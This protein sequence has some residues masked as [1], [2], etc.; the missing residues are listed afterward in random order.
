[1]GQVIKNS[2]VTVFLNRMCL[3]SCV[4]CNVVD[5]NLDKRRMYTNLWKDAFSILEKEG[6][7]F[8]L[9]IGTEPL[10]MRSGL[11]DLVKFWKERDYEYGL[12]TTA[13][14]GL[15]EELSPK[16]IEA[17]L[18]NWSSGIDFIPEVYSAFMSR[19]LLSR[20]CIDLVEK[21]KDGLVRKAIDGLDGMRIMVESSVEELLT[22]ITI[23][24]MN[25]EM[26]PEMISW[27]VKELGRKVHIGFN[28]I[29]VSRGDDMDFA[30]SSKECDDYLFHPEDKPI[31]DKFIQKMKDLPEKIQLRIQIPLDYLENWDRVVNMDYP[32]SEEFCVMSI[33]CDGILRKCGYGKGKH[34]CGYTVF[35]IPEWG[36][37]IRRAWEKDIKEC[38]G[39]YWAFPY[40]LRKRG[41]QSVDFRS[42]WWKDRDKKWRNIRCVVS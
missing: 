15:V 16:L 25:I 22:L 29:E 38:E 3:R 2:C 8:F 34:V 7:K 4:Y 35:D 20:R 18:R 40:L 31:F 9:L 14:K 5:S 39:C 21:E 28:Y 6:V 24:R 30:K 17:G 23:S 32:A 27:I 1:M 33:E 10:L 19:T 42:D 37:E 13:P 36:A 12:Y 26:V 11:V 41:G